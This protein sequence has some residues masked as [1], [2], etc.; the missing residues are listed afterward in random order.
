MTLL[1]FTRSKDEKIVGI[2]NWFPTHGTSM[3]RNNTHVAGDNKALAAWMVEQDA[4]S[5]G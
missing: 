4:R 1:R 5:N 2:L 3:Y